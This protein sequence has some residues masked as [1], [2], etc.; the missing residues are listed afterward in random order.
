MAGFDAGDVERDREAMAVGSL[1]LSSR[2]LEHSAITENWI[3]LTSVLIEHKIGR[4]VLS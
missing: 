3:L 1:A 4:R 2:P